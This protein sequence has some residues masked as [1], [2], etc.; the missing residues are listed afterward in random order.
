MKTARMV[1]AL[2]LGLAALLFAVKRELDGA[3]GAKAAHTAPRQQ[4]DNVRES[5]RRIE[6]DAQRRVDEALR[7]TEPQ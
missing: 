5:A 6:D 1:L 7:K 4:L 3:A 2:L